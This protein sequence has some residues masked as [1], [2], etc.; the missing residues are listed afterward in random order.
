M[1]LLSSA[2]RCGCK[3]IL[4]CNLL[5]CACCCSWIRSVCGGRTTTSNKAA[6]QQEASDA[7]RKAKRKLARGLCGGAV[8]EAEEPLTSEAKK[9]RTNTAATIPEPQ[10]CKWTKKAR[11]KKKT[12]NEQNGLAALVEEISLST[13]SP[14]HRAAAGEILRIGNHNIPSRVFTFRELVD[15]T[16]SF[17]PENLLGEG[18]FGRVYKGCI[19]DTMEVIAVKQLDKDGL[20]GNRE[21]LVEV[22]MLSLLHHPNLVTLVGYSTDCDQRILVY[23]YMSLGSLQDHLLDLSPKSQPLSWHTRM[24]IA[25]GAA[26]GIEYLHE[27]ANPPVIYRD[28]KASNILLDASFNA[29]LSDFG[30]AK[31]GPSGDN[32]HV[33]TRVMGTY[34]YCAPEYAMTGK[35]TKTSDI[36]SFGVVLLELITG[37]RAIDTTKPTR[38]Q[39]LVHWAAPFFRD[40]RKF[41]K[42]ADPLLDMKFPLKGLYQALAISSM[43][44]QEEASSRPLISDVVTALTFLADPNYDPPDDIK[45]PLPITVPNLDMETTGQNGTEGGK[46]QLQQN[47]GESRHSTKNEE[48]GS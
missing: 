29:K 30:L 37:R 47:E 11:K 22:L 10:K 8:R 38:E 16:N 4:S 21:F 15:A 9:K 13:D 41:V 19:P 40:K 23:E 27:V 32:T 17:C 24:K 43:C 2:N 35:L 39:I 5:R 45:D 31:L 42:M 33:S 20:Q 14:K 36:Y 34:G 48:E 26:R 25:V 18:G 44:L 46:E 12:K 3:N 6:A 7:E 28:L 1:G